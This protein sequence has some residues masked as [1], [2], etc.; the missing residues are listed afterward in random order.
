VRDIIFTNEWKRPIYF[1]VTVSP[2][3]KIGLDDYLWFHGLAWRLEPR[4]VGREDFG[5][6]KSVLEANLMQEPAEPSK[7][8]QYGYRFR[9]VADPG[10]YFDENTSRLMLNYRSA[11]MRLALYYS[12]ADADTARAIATLNRMEELIPRSKVPMGWELLSDL[13]TF[14][15]RLGQTETFNQIAG[16][17]E[18]T[19]K[20]MIA[21]GRADASSP[22]N[23][24]RV[25]FSIYEQKQDWPAM[26]ELLTQLTQQYPND[27]GLRQ[28]IAEVQALVNRQA[29][30]QPDSARIGG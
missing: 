4:R 20:E 5:I 18:G 3:S 16:E 21:S 9:R 7:G 11:F 27:P 24:Y 23:P 6:E 22:Y 15:A 25:L 29:P 30:K 12:N 13:G 10:V 8:P 19:M 14:Y 2:D 28:R 26:L 17:L 1:A